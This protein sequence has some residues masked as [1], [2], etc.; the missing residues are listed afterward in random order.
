[1]LSDFS[2][3]FRRIYRQ[4]PYDYDS[5]YKKHWLFIK[6]L[7]KRILSLSLN[8]QPYVF[9]EKYGCGLIIWF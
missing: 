6:Q 4:D 3:C 2:F 9:V 8:E 7:R 5:A 1:M